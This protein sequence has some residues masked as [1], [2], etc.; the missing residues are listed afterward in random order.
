MI[1]GHGDIA[2]ALSNRKDRLYFASGVSNSSEIRESEYR[3]EI[4]LLL[5]QNRLGKS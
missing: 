1:I 5:K 2:S 3:R 4:N